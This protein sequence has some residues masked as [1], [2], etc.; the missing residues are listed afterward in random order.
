MYNVCWDYSWAE[1]DRELCH[2]TFEYQYYFPL[3]PIILTVTWHLL[4]VSYNEKV[5]QPSFCNSHC[6]GSCGALHKWLC[7]EFWDKSQ[8]CL[9]YILGPFDVCHDLLGNSL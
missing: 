4:L 7:W 8:L 3:L 6:K 2:T 5:I 9:D 1:A